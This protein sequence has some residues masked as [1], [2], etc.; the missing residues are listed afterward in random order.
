MLCFLLAG[1]RGL[2]AEG[3]V[4]RLRP[5][6]DGLT[7][8]ICRQP[9][10]LGG[11]VLSLASFIFALAMLALQ[12]P[13][14]IDLSP[15]GAMFRL[16]NVLQFLPF[17]LIGAAMCRHRPLLDWMTRPDVATP[18]LAMGSALLFATVSLDITPVADPRLQ[19]VLVAAFACLAGVFWLR[20]LLGFSSRHLAGPNRLFGY[21]SAASYTIYL[22]H[23]P[24]AL[25]MGALLIG[26]GLSAGTAFSVNLL[27]TLGL[28]VALHEGVRR[29][30]LLTYLLN[31]KRP[32]TVAAVA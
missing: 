21:F 19:R 23:L 9:G 1:L 8:W 30:S 17:F 20:L 24:I 10:W 6:A 26:S 12:G 16:T 22:V 5:V 7:R 15:F 25:W 2:A 3:P 29:S 13:L 31:G 14:G 4:A 18:F 28:S 32:K 27:V 11:V